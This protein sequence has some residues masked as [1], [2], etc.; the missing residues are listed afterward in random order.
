MIGFIPNDVNSL[1]VHGRRRS[2]VTIV[3]VPRKGGER[4]IAPPDEFSV[5]R[6]E[7]E[8]VQAAGL[9]TGARKKNA[10]TPEDGRGMSGGRQLDL[11]IDVGITDFCGDRLGVADARAVWP[12]EPG[13]LLGGS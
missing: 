9:V 6:A 2:G 8:H 1:G 7:A 5:H 4:E 11:P 3:L 12:A 10:V 13:P